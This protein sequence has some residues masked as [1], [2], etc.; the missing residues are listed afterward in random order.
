MKKSG[1]FLF[2]MSVIS[3]L[4]AVFDVIRIIGFYSD[5]KKLND[6]FGYVTD[7]YKE[8]LFENIF[9]SA[10]AFAAEAVLGVLGII[11]S[12]KGGRFKTVCV[13]LGIL[14]IFCAFY[15][16]L[17]IALYNLYLIDVYGLG[18]ICFVLYT[19]AAFKSRK[20]A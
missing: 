13:C 2:V 20:A 8:L 4:L 18:L 9:L 16:Y 15:G 6:I 3:L 19:A 5:Y 7:F 17:Y 10:I 1:V 11:G 14:L 12:V